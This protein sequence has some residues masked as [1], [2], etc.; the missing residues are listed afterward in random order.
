MPQLPIIEVMEEMEK[1]ERELTSLRHGYGL[2]CI[3][4]ILVSILG[5][6]LLIIVGIVNIKRLVELF[7]DFHIIIRFGPGD[8]Q[9]FEVD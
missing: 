2:T 6:F 3:I 9:F 5:S 1:F 4:F 7:P 8:I